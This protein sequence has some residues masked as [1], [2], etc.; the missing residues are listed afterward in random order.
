MFIVCANY[1]DLVIIEFI[2][3][4]VGTDRWSSQAEQGGWVEEGVW[5]ASTVR[6]LFAADQDEEGGVAGGGGLA[7]V[8][9]GE[10]GSGVDTEGRDLLAA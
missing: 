6:G 2:F 3:P 5:S 9:A 7:S 4:A 1:D 10:G 8:V